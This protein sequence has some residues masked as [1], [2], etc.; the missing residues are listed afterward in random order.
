MRVAAEMSLS[1]W[2]EQTW[3]DKKLRGSGGTNSPER[4][5]NPL[6]QEDKFQHLPSVVRVLSLME[7]VWVL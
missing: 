1:V 3:Q 7:G 5:E 4:G 6:S 2:S